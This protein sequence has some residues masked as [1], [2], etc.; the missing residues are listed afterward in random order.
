[1]VDLQLV[2]QADYLNSWIL[3]EIILQIFDWK[4]KKIIIQYIFVYIYYIYIYIYIYM[5][6]CMYVYIKNI[7][8]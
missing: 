1:M 2:L 3:L 6:V 5:Y 8:M 7:N 4:I